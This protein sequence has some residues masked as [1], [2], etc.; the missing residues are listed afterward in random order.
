MA[1]ITKEEFG[2]SASEFSALC[3][4]F[5]KHSLLEKGFIE[6]EEFVALTMDIGEQ[7][8]RPAPLPPSPTHI[9]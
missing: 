6:K 2:L 3:A 1:D 4:V 9:L 8:R 7:V 5:E